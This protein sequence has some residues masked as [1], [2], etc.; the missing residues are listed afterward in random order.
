MVAS[1]WGV[2]DVEKRV[3]YPVGFAERN[4]DRRL[5]K[6]RI[7]LRC[8]RSFNAS[9]GLDEASCPGR[10]SY[11][12]FD[13]FLRFS[14]AYLLG[15]VLSHPNLLLLMPPLGVLSF[16]KVAIPDQCDWFLFCRS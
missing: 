4:H 9:T 8:R 12:D 15:A 6:C 14:L 16:G 3:S 5:F 10:W 13:V 2:G 7:I 1:C 11:P